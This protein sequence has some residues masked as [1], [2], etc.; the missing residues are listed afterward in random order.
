VRSTRLQQLIA[1]SPGARLGA[2]I[3][4]AG[5]CLFALAT[6]YRDAGFFFAGLLAAEA[7]AWW[8]HRDFWR[9]TR[10]DRV[11][12]LSAQRTGEST[13]NVHLD[14]VT[15]KRLT[16]AQNTGNR[17]SMAIAGVLLLAIPVAAAVRSGTLWWLLALPASAV[18]VFMGIRSQLGEPARTRRARLATHLPGWMG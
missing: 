4:I 1:T 17:I 12:V 7:A 11:R 5:P 9:L 6:W 16:F 14:A 18:A 3:V 15:L 10:H 2:D 13:G 8:D